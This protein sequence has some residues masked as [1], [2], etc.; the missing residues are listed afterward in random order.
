VDLEKAQAKA[1]AYNQNGRVLFLGVQ[2]QQ[3]F[4]ANLFGAK[5]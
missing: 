2:I 3:P 5:T 1:V 4:P